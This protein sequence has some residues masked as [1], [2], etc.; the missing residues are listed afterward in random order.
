VSQRKQPFDRKRL[1][2]AKHIEKVGAAKQS[3]RNRKT[4]SV[5]REKRV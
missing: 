5:F 3:Y 1:G 4:L 2:E